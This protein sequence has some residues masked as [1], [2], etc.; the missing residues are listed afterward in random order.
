MENQNF[1]DFYYFFLNKWLMYPVKVSSTCNPYSIY[2]YNYAA[3][4]A[5]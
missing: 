5:I 1:P 4:S 2:I 3:Q